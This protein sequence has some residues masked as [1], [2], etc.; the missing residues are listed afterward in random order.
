MISVEERS[1]QALKKA[2]EERKQVLYISSHPLLIHQRRRQLLEITAGYTGI[3]WA[4][5]NQFTEQILQACGVAYVRIDQATREDL[6]ES[7]ML[8]LEAQ[9]KLFLLKN[10]LR[11]AGMNKSVALWIEDLEKRSGEEWIPFLKTVDEPVLQELNTVYEA[12][13]AQTRLKEFPYK[14]TEQV[15]HIAD[16]LFKEEEAARNLLA[17]VVVVEGYFPHT[18]GVTQLLETIR[19]LASELVW[20]PPVSVDFSLANKRKLRFLVGTTMNDE[21]RVVVDDLMGRL[22]EGVPEDEIVVAAPDHLYIQAVKRELRAQGLLIQAERTSS[23]LELPVTKRILSLLQLRKNNWNRA[24]LLTC[25]KLYASLM[26]LSDAEVAWGRAIITESGVMEGCS[27]WLTLFRGYEARSRSRLEHL[28]GEGD[29]EQVVWRLA[30]AKKWIRFLCNLE[31]WLQSIPMAATWER[32]LEQALLIVDMDQKKAMKSQAKAQHWAEFEAVRSCLRTRLEIAMTF[33]TANDRMISLD[34][35]VNWFRERFSSSLLSVERVENGI[36][37]CLPE[38]MYG[39]T[40]AHVYLLGLV[41]DV[42]PRAFHPHWIWDLCQRNSV[43]TNVKGPSAGEQEQYDHRFFQWAALAGRKEI[44]FSYPLRGERGR[45]TVVSRYMRDLLKEVDRQQLYKQKITAPTDAH[46]SSSNRGNDSLRLPQFFDPEIP[47]SVTGID[48]YAKCAFRYFAGRVLS[49]GESLVRKEG[50]LPSDIGSIMHQVLRK[51]IGESIH[52]PQDLT[53]KTEALLAE[54]LENYER[55][56]GFAGPKWEGQR[57][58]LKRELYEFVLT[59]V[60]GFLHKERGEQIAE[61]GFGRLH[62]EKMDV[63]SNPEPLVLQNDSCQVRVT[64]MVDRIDRSSEG[65]SV[66]DYKL[67][68]SPTRRDIEQGLDLQMALYMIAYSTHS[69]NKSVPLGGRFA[70]LRDPGKG[71]GIEFDSKEGFET[72]Q[73][74]VMNLI[75]ELAD[76]M[77]EGDVM[78]RPRDI[79]E[80]KTCSYRGVCRRDEYKQ[81]G[82]K[83]E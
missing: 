61:W 73:K 2:V 5:L 16:N 69:E 31:R 39:T 22:E 7:M 68:T 10:G 76:R 47:I 8:R 28:Q 14:E 82:S 58:I 52:S 65:F 40:F 41:E 81:G 62:A 77:A 24:Y 37:V 26:G 1:I 57:R 23:L 13:I 32:F 66:V 75:F 60:D 56:Y 48:L 44:I 30:S 34:R 64:G 63:S 36:R 80:C 54:E 6:V 46:K 15:Y 20:I 50:L 38:E 25:T 21:A 17:D 79:S 55:R 27:N 29:T 11:F 53:A 67:S 78:P 18:E 72:F 19:G 59:E 33:A 9:G 45:S 3:R 35:F 70:V 71:G 83:R 4:T 51:L 49:V 74:Q 42:W 12:Y 43:G